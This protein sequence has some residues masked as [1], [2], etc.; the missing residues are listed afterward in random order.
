ML[1]GHRPQ[2][3]GSLFWPSKLGVKE[4]AAGLG[5]DGTYAAFGHPILVM[6]ADPRDRNTL[7]IC[8]NFAHEF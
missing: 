3:S 5:N 7:E 2:V 8:F 6:G 1:D 4:L